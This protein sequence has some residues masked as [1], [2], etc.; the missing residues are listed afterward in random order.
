MVELRIDGEDEVL[1]ELP[2]TPDGEGCCAVERLHDLPARGI[3]LRTRALTTTMFSRFLL[4]DLF[5]HGIGGAKYDELGN[6]IS[7]RFFGFEPPGFLT[8]SLT[9]WLGLDVRARLGGSVSLGRAAA[10]RPE[11]QSGSVPDRTDP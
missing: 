10:P 6:E 3:R 7:S 9:L 11:I 1:M 4:G 8:L 2:L 5:I